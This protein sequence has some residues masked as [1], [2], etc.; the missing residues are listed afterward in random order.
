MFNL[1]MKQVHNLLRSTYCHWQGPAITWNRCIGSQLIWAMTLGGRG[2]WDHQE[3]K[4]GGGILHVGSV[5]SHCY[6]K[7]FGCW[8]RSPAPDLP[9]RSKELQP[10]SSAA[11]V[12]V[13]GWPGSV[14]ALHTRSRS[15]SSCQDT[16]G[17]LSQAA[18][19]SVHQRPWS[20]L[21]PSLCCSLLPRQDCAPRRAEPIADG[22]S[23]GLMQR[24]C[25]PGRD[26]VAALPRALQCSQ[27]ERLGR[28]TGG[29]EMEEGKDL[30]GELAGRKLKLEGIEAT[31]WSDSLIMASDWQMHVW[32]RQKP[33]T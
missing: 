28:K 8:P 10:L 30:H 17:A 32:R 29:R 14:S 24:S 11:A 13:A 5:L 23:F 16:Q 27:Q 18:P 4:A 20:C 9:A 22:R 31:L 33:L 1:S 3:E 26:L 19:E 15:F 6:I 25:Q 2:W 12:G 7:P 21:L